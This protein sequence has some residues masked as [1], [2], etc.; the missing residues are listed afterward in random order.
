V[1][2]LVTI[3]P[4]ASDKPEGLET[5]VKAANT[6]SVQMQWMYEVSKKGEEVS[7]ENPLV[8]SMDG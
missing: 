8:P 1:V 6:V 3:I 2:G 4:P 7:P 5:I